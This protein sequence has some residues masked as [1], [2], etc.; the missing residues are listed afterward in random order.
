MI[1]DMERFG[2]MQLLR[3]LDS[4]RQAQEPFNPLHREFGFTPTPTEDN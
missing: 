1:L 4:Q 2:E 3:F